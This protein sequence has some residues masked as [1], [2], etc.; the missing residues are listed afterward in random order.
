V[1]LVLESLG[2]PRNDPLVKDEA[3]AF[4]P[5]PRFVRTLTHEISHV[6][7][8]HASPAAGL[9]LVFRR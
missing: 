6:L 2:L 5:N 9:P 7:S 1:Q 4:V 8:S 3:A